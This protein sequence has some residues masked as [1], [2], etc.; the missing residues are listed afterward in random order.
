MPVDVNRC[1]RCGYDGSG[2]RSTDVCP[3]CGAARTGAATPLDRVSPLR[4][5]ERWIVWVAAAILV[6]ACIAL[7]V[8]LWLGGAA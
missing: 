8:F 2:L 1:L 3:E 7:I 5:Q 4:R 6:G